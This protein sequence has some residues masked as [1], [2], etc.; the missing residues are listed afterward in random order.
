M[1]RQ[2]TGDEF[3]QNRRVLG[4]SVRECAH[5]MNVNERVLR[6][7]E[8]G[9]SLGPHPSSARIMEWMLDG[10]RPPEWPE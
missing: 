5:I 1:K 2:M 10:F 8:S 7:W 6:K 9:T 3:K 4:L